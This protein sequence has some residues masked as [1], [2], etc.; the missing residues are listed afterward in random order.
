VEVRVLSSAPDFTRLTA[1][2]VSASQASHRHAKSVA[3]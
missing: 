1:S 3:P 2:F